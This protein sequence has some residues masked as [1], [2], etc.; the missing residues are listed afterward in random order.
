MRKPIR[1]KVSGATFVIFCLP[2][3]PFDWNLFAP[4]AQCPPTTRLRPFLNMRGPCQAAI[5]TGVVIKCD[6][7]G[8]LRIKQK[9]PTVR[10]HL[11]RAIEQFF[12]SSLLGT[13]KKLKLKGWQ[14]AEQAATS[15]IRG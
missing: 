15:L 10:E 3:T 4:F 7:L 8:A 12:F 9:G 14:N 2:S 13:S 11:G 6:L 5:A 1:F